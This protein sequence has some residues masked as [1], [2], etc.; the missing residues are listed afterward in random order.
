MP[1]LVPVPPTQPYEH[2]I[3]VRHHAHVLPFHAVS[4][5]VS[6]SVC[7]SQPPEVAI[8][9]ADHCIAMFAIADIDG[10]E[11]RAYIA[12]IHYLRAMPVSV[13]FVQDAYTRYVP[14]ISVKQQ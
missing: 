6:V 9:F 13:V 7:I 8:S 14:R 5:E 1:C 11:G 4:G 2:D 10:R 3:L 12:A